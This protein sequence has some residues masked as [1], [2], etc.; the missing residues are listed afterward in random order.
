MCGQINLVPAWGYPNTTGDEDI[1]SSDIGQF[2]ERGSTRSVEQITDGVATNV[3]TTTGN[4][5]LILTGNTGNTIPV[6]DLTTRARTSDATYSGNGGTLPDA[7]HTIPG[8]HFV[9]STALEEGQLIIGST[10]KLQA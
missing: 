9:I 3:G 2:G 10:L 6:S 8:K 4:G 1:A 5:Q 7:G